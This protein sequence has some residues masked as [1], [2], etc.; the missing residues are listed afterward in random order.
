MS[1]EIGDRLKAIRM[2]LGHS[3]N[4]VAKETGINRSTLANYEAG[5]SEPKAAQLDR[6]AWFYGVPASY[7]LY[8]DLPQ[9]AGE[10][11]PS[12]QTT[13]LMNTVRGMDEDKISLVADL[14]E[15]VKKH[16]K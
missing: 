10:T 7:I 9:Q 4:Y 2:N 6:L 12:P 13:R 11:T 3:Q 14:A 16:T 1:R 8:G 5:D 15:A